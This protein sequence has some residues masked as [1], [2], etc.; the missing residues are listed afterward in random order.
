MNQ[1]NQDEKRVQQIRDEARAFMQPYF[2]EM[3]KEFEIQCHACSADNC[4][5]NEACINCGCQL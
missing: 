3:R 2:E 5:C 1:E 4:K